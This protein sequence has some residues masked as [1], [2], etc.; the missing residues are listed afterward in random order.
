M[1]NDD[2]GRLELDVVESQYREVT[3]PQ[4]TGGQIQ[5]NAPPP[6]P[7]EATIKL[8][9]L[10]QKPELLPILLEHTS[11]G[12]GNRRMLRVL[13]GPLS[14]DDIDTRDASKQS[15][16]ERDGAMVLAVGVLVNES[17]KNGQFHTI[18]ELSSLCSVRPAYKKYTKKTSVSEH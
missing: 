14:G 12:G 9:R 13:F 15:A 7:G 11:H 2:Q 18:Q 4:L 8:H 1:F 17:F 6:N 3:Y 16:S 5:G 10:W